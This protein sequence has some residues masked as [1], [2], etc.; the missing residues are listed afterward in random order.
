MGIEDVIEWIN[1]ADND[2]DSAKILNEAVQK[3][4]EVICYLCAQAAEKYLKGYLTSKDIIPEKTH[5]L[6]FLN[7]LCVEKDAS[8]EE[9]KIV[10]DF[11]NRFANDIRYPHKYDVD[12]ND[13]NFA[14]GAIDKMR[15]L[16]PIL[17]L[18]NSAAA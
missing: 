2:F 6:P 5:N 17:D 10:C 9:I 1:I 15:N 11:L 13:A 4:S 12:K 18:R 14:I 16:K 7:S 8:F 3:H